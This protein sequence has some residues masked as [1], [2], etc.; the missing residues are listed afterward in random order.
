VN[1]IFHKLKIPGSDRCLKLDSLIIGKKQEK[2][3][4]NIRIMYLSFIIEL[5]CSK[6]KKKKLIRELRMPESKL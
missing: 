2:L 1:K 3:E 6:K 4:C 5:P